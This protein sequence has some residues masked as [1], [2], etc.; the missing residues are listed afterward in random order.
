MVP[1]STKAGRRADSTADDVAPQALVGRMTEWRG[2]GGEWNNWEERRRGEHKKARSNHK[3]QQ[4][5]EAER[6]PPTA[7]RRSLHCS[8]PCPILATHPAS[9]PCG[10]PKNIRRAQHPR[11]PT[12]DRPPPG[13]HQVATHRRRCTTTRWPVIQ[14]ASLTDASGLG[15]R[16]PAW[17]LASQ[18]CL[19]SA[20]APGDRPL[21]SRGPDMRRLGVDITGLSTKQFPVR[22]RHQSLFPRLHLRQSTEQQQWVSVP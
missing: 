9:L 11:G 8:Y 21:L 6:N 14:T 7:I 3:L 22:L 4:R 20:S 18:Q 16:P 15:G 10:H 2:K 19:V 5:K 12:S 13:Y 1:W 17:S